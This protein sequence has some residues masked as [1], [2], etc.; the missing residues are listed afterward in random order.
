MGVQADNLTRQA[1]STLTVAKAD[2]N[3]TFRRFVQADGKRAAA[4]KR[5]LGVG[6]VRSAVKDALIPV[7]VCGVVPVEAGAAIALADGEKA[8]MPDA[9]GRA[10][11][12]AGN[13]PVA[14]FA[15][16]AAT[17]AG[18]IVPVLIVQQVGQ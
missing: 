7:D 11:A 16:G 4:G 15:L 13:V 14:G 6:A 8:V 1:T 17:A 2:A 9:D 10:V 18:D 3:E 12:H 5:P